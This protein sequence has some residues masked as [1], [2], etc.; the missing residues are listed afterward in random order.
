MYNHA[1]TEA[2]HKKAA[3]GGGKQPLGEFVCFFRVMGR[4]NFVLSILRGCH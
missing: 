1:V 4:C 3:S 2:W